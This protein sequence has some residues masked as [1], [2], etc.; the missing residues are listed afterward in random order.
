MSS[1]HPAHKV[2]SL[3]QSPR[4][5]GLFGLGWFA[6][7]AVGGIAL[8]GEPP[9]YDAPISEI[10]DFFSSHG[11][12]YLVGDYIAEIG[13]VLLFLPFV[14]VLRGLLGRA[15]G[16]L[17]VRS[18]LA[19]VGAVLLVV[20][21]GGATAFLDAVALGRAG[22]ELSD[23]TIRALLLANAVAIA[24]LGVAA[25]LFV[26]SASIVIWDTGVLW[27]G[28]AVVGAGAGVLLITGA[29]FP[30]EDDA[31]GI[32]W[33]VRFASFIA[34]AIFVLLSSVALLSGADR[35]GLPAR[36]NADN[37]A[38]HQARS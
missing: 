24:A 5:G 12:R 37:L 25:A 16:G 8:Q 28:L 7:F 38:E 17:Q 32:L 3:L 2:T 10:R 4:V 36:V 1:E 31:D 21:G 33:T 14:A 29:A 26:L 15:E 27:R 20:L 18:R 30:I 35:L 22:P 11:Q 19:F 34:L 13:F 6:L 23:S 9:G